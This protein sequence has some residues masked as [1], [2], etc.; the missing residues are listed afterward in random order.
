MNHVANIVAGVCVGYLLAR[1]AIV[2]VA[3]IA[4]RLDEKFFDWLDK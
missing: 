3:I 4:L 2:I 1:A